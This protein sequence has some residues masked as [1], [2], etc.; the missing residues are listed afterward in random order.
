LQMGGIAERLAPGDRL[1]LLIYAFHA[2]FPVTWSR[3]LVIP[4]VQLEGTVELPLL[5]PSEI[6]HSGV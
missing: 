6:V 4:A 3:D 5:A 2:Q 1:A